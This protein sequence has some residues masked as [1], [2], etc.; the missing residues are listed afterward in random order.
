MSDTEQAFTAEERAAMKDR[1]QEVRRAR[2]GK[3]SPED[4][5]RDLLAK[6][7]ELPEPERTT[8]LRIHAIVT[9]AAPQLAPKLWYGMPG[10]AKGGKNLVFFQSATKFRTRYATLGFNDVARLDDGDAWSTAYAIAAL[11][12]EVETRI[13]ELVRRA[14][15]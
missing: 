4:D 12:P 5:L 9:A 13:A 11:T 14:V 15:G 2:R 7:D 8:A 6:I 3:A 1:A 10:W